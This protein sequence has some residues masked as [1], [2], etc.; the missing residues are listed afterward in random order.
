MNVSSVDIS[1]T[2]MITVKKGISQN[3]QTGCEVGLPQPKS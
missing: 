2:M 1:V 3:S